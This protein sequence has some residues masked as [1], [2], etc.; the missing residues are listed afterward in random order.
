MPRARNIKPSLFKNELLG[1]ADPLLTILFTG[2]W[3]LADRRGRLENRPKRIKAEIFP[4]RE[5]PLFNGYLTELEQMGFLHTYSVG[6]NQYIQIENFEKHQHPHKTEKASDIP[7]SPLKTDTCKVTEDAPLNNGCV[8]EEARLIPDSSNTDS[9][10]TENNVTALPTAGAVTVPDCP[11]QEIIDAYHAAC[12][13]LRQVR[14]WNAD[15]QKHLRARWRENPKHQTLDFWKKYFEYVNTSPFLRGDSSDFAA[16]LEWLIKP[17][18][19]AKVIE[20]KYADK[21]TA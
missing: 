16:D 6:D 13:T 12:P 8:T 18:N 5:L 10:N 20:G 9:S 11:H 15:R 4:Y 3:C 2:L 17:S 14:S 7:D 21:E 19:F 1:E